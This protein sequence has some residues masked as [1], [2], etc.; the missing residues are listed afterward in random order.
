MPVWGLEAPNLG[1]E[2]RRSRRRR[3]RP[4]QSRV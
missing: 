1:A 2:S 3:G 4:D